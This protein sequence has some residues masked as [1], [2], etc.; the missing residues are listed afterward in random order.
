MSL[1]MSWKKVKQME[2]KA[3]ES[4]NL[5][6]VGYDEEKELLEI[7]FKNGSVYQYADV[8]EEIHEEL[9][10]AESKGRYLR[11]KI[12]KGYSYIKMG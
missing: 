6:S 4:S 10:N 5:K 12:T 9:M 8:P 3:V 11:E 1:V 2:R 7:E